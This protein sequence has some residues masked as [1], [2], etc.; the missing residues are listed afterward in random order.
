MPAG[1]SELA[2]LV[3][4]GTEVLAGEGALAA[5]AADADI[6]LNGVVGFE[7]LPVTLAALRPG[8]AWPWPTRSH[9]SPAARLCCRHCAPLERRSCPSIPSTAP[10]INA[11]R[12]CRSAEI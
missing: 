3:P 7:G 4:E 2:A 11:C 12:D 5:I 9:L 10:F 1:P 6:V 8:G